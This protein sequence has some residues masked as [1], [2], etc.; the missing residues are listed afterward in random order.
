MYEQDTL[1]CMRISN[2]RAYNLSSPI[3]PSDKR[4]FYGGTRTI[5]KRDVVLAIVEAADG[6]VDMHRLVRVV[7]PCTSIST[8][9]L[10]TT[11]LS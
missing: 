4:D 7:R 11:S 2:I 5:N 8:M 3:D 1:G 9:P 10:M 6:E